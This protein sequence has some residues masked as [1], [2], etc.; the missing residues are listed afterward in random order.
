MSNFNDDCFVGKINPKSST[1]KNF[2]F[3]K[4][5]L[6]K[7]TFAQF[8]CVIAMIETTISSINR[9]FRIYK[10]SENGDALDS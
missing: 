4:K 8:V 1:R 2:G 5:F 7:N 6:R 9:N 3:I 10:L